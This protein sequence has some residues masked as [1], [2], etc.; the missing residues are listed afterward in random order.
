M[1]LGLYEE[2]ISELLNSKLKKLPDGID[3]QTTDIDKAEASGV[4]AAYVAQQ[5]QSILEQASS[6][7]IHEQIRLV[8]KMLAAASGESD[9]QP[10]T[11]VDD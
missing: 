6:K 9:A 2:V 4:L 3:V 5:T 8:N 1:R 10:T 7:G 11:L